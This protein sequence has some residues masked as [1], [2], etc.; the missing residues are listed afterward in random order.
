MMDMIE[1]I[2][3]VEDERRRLLLGG[4]EEAI[5]KQHNEGKLT[6]RER[7]ERFLDPQTFQE[8]DLWS[9]PLQTSSD[10]T[11]ELS[12]LFLCSFIFSP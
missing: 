11:V 12:L 6:A 7:V 8:L 9:T 5:A 1:K 4:G 2:R 3:E 10:N